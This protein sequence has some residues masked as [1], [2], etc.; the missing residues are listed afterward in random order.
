MCG[1]FLSKL[2]PGNRVASAHETHLFHG[3]V[4]PC[5]RASISATKGK[6]NLADEPIETS[7]RVEIPVARPREF[8][9][10]YRPTDDMNKVKGVA[11]KDMAR[12]KRVQAENLVIEKMVN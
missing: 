5:Y 3:L 7:R 4:P 8:P 12:L 10:L 6:A 1:S 11:A 2:K 9:P